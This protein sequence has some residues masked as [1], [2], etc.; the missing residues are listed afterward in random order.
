L[1]YLATG[2]YLFGTLA[3]QMVFY[4]TLSL[5]AQLLGGVAVGLAMVE[6]SLAHKMDRL[7]MHA[8]IPVIWGLLFVFMRAGSNDAP[9]WGSSEH[10]L[11]VWLA[12]GA[13]VIWACLAGT[14]NRVRDNLRPKN[15]R[16]QWD[17]WHTGLMSAVGF[18][19]LCLLFEGP[20]L[21]V[22]FG[23]VMVLLCVLSLRPGLKPAL[24]MALAFLAVAFIQ[25]VKLSQNAAFSTSNG[26]MFVT[27]GV[28]FLAIAYAVICEHLRLNIGRKTSEG[29][30]WSSG[31][32]A[33]IMLFSIFYLRRDSLESYVTVL[34]GISAFTVLAA[35]FAGRV[36]GLRFLALGAFAACIGRAFMVD[37][38]ETVAR[39]WAFLALG[40][41]LLVVGYLYTQFKDKIIP[42]EDK[43]K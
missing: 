35:G 2:F 13:A 41:G 26:F 7:T 1:Q 40:V 11:L 29:L 16:C 43:T 38:L 37:I 28:S 31:L 36:R 33:L 22:A 23:A 8:S 9:Q 18:V 17:W 42:V 15:D 6:A 4:K 10:A 39:I 12:M 20:A 27:I 3:L 14:W 32:M 34:W 30:E 5:E 24:P 19:G 25:F 21:M